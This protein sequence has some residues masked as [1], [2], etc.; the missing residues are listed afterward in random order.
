[1]ADFFMVSRIDNPTYLYYRVP[2]NYLNSKFEF[3]PIK[4]FEKF[5]YA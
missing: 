5:S 1:M 3:Q 4:A 2:H